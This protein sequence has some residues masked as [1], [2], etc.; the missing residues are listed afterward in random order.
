MTHVFFVFIPNLGG[1][2]YIF[3]VFLLLL[4]WRE[5]QERPE[6]VF[7]CWK[8]RVRLTTP[9]HARP[10]W[11]KYLYSA[12]VFCV[13]DALHTALECTP[14]YDYYSPF[15]SFPEG[16]IS[17]KTFTA[18]RFKCATAVFSAPPTKRFSTKHGTVMF[19]HNIWIGHFVCSLGGTNSCSS[20][21]LPSSCQWSNHSSTTERCSSVVR[22]YG[23]HVIT[24]CP[25]PFLTDPCSDLRSLRPSD[26]RKSV[27]CK[28][29]DFALVNVFFYTE[30]LKK[31]I[32]TGFH[33]HE[34]EYAKRKID[35]LIG[36]A[37]P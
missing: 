12:F 14:L 22:L 7:S 31:F 36:R 27:V 10:D 17:T 28:L 25:V 11:W 3:F 15:F 21:G 24:R 18:C 2:F 35:F 19:Y 37:S 30:M 5:K 6:W 1:L 26:D 13:F 9:D 33:F 29:A 34:N 8:D 20:E 16:K 23:C 4:W 32:P